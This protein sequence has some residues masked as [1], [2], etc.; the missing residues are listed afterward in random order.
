MILT[1]NSAE[2]HLISDSF[3]DFF[4]FLVWFSQDNFLLIIFMVVLA[5]LDIFYYCRI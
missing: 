3:V 2:L 1:C 5:K 4:F